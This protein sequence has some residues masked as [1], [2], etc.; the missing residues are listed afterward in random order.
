MTILSLILL[1][2]LVVLL[3]RVG[4]SILRFLIK[5]GILVLI[6]YLAYQGVIWIMAYIQNHPL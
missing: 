3:F 4:L 1:V 2:L 6:I 5:A